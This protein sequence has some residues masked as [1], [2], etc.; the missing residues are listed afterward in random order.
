MTVPLP[1]PGSLGL[2]QYAGV[3]MLAYADVCVVAETA[4]M[5]RELTQALQASRYESDLC[6]SMAERVK[7]LEAALREY[8]DAAD[9]SI[10]ASDDVAAMLRFGDADKAARAALAKDA[11]SNV[12]TA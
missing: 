6:E 9:N 7:V 8:I 11:P 4:D 10:T 3:D 12:P 2:V 1:L 5:R